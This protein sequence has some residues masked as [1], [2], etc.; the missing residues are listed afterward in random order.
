MSGDLTLP[1]HKAIYDALSG[2]APFVAL[3]GGRIYDHVPQGTAYPYTDLGETTNLPWD[4]DGGLGTEATFTIHHWSRLRGMLEVRRIMAAAYDVLH[5][6]SLPIVGGSL[7]VMTVEFQ[8]AFD[9][10]DGIT[11]H[12][13]QRIR[14]KLHE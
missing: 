11:R 8:T 7:A 5:H 3:V 10:P 12:G 2:D 9:D 14:A 1:L 4:T 13:V 6:A